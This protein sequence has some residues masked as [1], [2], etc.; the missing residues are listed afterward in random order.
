MLMTDVPVL[1]GL[2]LGISTAKAA[3]FDGQGSA[4]GCETQEYLILPQGGSVEADPETYWTPVVASIRR[5]LTHWKGDPE[6]IRAVSVASHTETVIP[7]QHSGKPVRPA[8]VWMDSRSQPEADELRRF[9][10]P[11][12]VL[13]ISGQPDINPIWPITKFRWMAKHEPDELRK[14]ATFLL[15]EG[16]LLYRLC[17]RFVAEQTEWSSS[18]VLD[19]RSKRWSE[20]MLEFAGVSSAQLPE[21]YAP[22]VAIGHISEAC[23]RETGLS[24]HTCVVTG[25]LDQVCSAIAA[26]NIAPGIITE[27]TGSVLALLA[28]VSKP[29]LDLKTRIPC[30]IHALPDTY[31]L[32]P[33]NPCGG[34]VLKWFK[35]NFVS[36]PEPAENVYDQLTADAEGIAPGCDGLIMLPHLQGALFPE[37][38]EA[39]RGVFFGISLG[40]KR[41][42]FVRAI[43]ESIGFLIR[44]DLEGLNRLGAGAK[45]IRVLGG[46]ARSW[47]WSQIKADICKLRVVVPEQPEAAALGAAI[48]AAVGSGVYRDIPSA[49]QAMSRAKESIEP[50][51]SHADIYDAAFHLY[52]S[53][54]IAVRELYPQHK[55]N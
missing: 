46:G 18:L 19:I 10:G 50:N 52:E 17:G 29:V 23:A 27:S 54:Y 22:G 15:P 53:L 4:L 6:R 39:A 49:V 26:G 45:E 11:D 51:R 24:R 34:L 36:A 33:W 8:L 38:N 55:Q 28:T 44:R 25:A 16:Y 5:L 3:L 12:R 37:Y 20:E 32:L 47:F 7:L 35:D 9:I 41:A 21:I 14:T 2:D 30:H 42:H 43:L 13:Q 48:L 40:H 31:C 1:L